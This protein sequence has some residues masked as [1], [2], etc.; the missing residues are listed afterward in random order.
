VRFAD[1][2]LSGGWAAKASEGVVGVDGLRPY[3]IQLGQRR[4]RV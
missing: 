4:G 3:K 1:R 2:D